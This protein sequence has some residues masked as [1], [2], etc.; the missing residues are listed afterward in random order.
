MKYND[1]GEIPHG[2]RQK[3][4]IPSSSVNSIENRHDKSRIV[5][6]KTSVETDDLEHGGDSQE[7][8]GEDRRDMTEL[9]SAI[10]LR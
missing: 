2:L 5:D 9:I 3:W 8:D 4:H 10:F 1:Q 7:Y 6:S